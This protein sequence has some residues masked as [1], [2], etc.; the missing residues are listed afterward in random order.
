MSFCPSTDTSLKA[1][2]KFRSFVRVSSRGQTCV[3]SFPEFCQTGRKSPMLEDLTFSR[4]Y[5]SQSFDSRFYYIFIGVL[6]R[7]QNP[8][9]PFFPEITILWIFDVFQS[10]N[11]CS[12]IRSSTF[13]SKLFQ[14]ELTCNTRYST[15]GT[16]HKSWKHIIHSVYNTYYMYSRCSTMKQW[17][18]VAVYQSHIETDPCLPRPDGTFKC[19][20]SLIYPTRTSQGLKVP[21]VIS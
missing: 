3:S 18:G 17:P 1:V 7:G 9:Y 19:G 13:C 14:T 4:I 8:M 2:V 12:A 5:K 20:S 10:F 15:R 11:S 21:P 6:T 16:I